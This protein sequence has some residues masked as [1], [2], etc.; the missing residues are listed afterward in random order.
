MY[1]K[2]KHCAVR[3]GRALAANTELCDTLCTPG[4][5]D[6]G[7]IPESARMTAEQCATMVV[8]TLA[9]TPCSAAN[10][11]TQ[12]V[13]VVPGSSIPVMP[14]MSIPASVTIQQ[15]AAD[16]VFNESNPYDPATRFSQ[17]FPAPPLPYV[18][19]ER[20]PTNEPKPSTAPCLP[21]QRFQG[22]RAALL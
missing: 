22:S 13:P 20:I 19:P 18:C 6:P 1:S 15:K 2:Y 8:T 16:A 7:A 14:V 9:H 12:D 10:R 5:A 4:I 11:V 3:T 17:Y 21:I